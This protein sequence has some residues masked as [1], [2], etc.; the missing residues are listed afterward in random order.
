M[1]WLLAREVL[2]LR[3]QIP[4]EGRWDVVVDLFFY[5][6]PEEVSWFFWFLYPT[7][8]LWCPF[9]HMS[10]HHGDTGYWGCLHHAKHLCDVNIA[11]VAVLSRLLFYKHHV[12]TLFLPFRLR[13]KSR[14]QRKLQLL[15]S[16]PRRTTALWLTLTGP[17]KLQLL[18]QLLRTGMVMLLL[19]LQLPLL[20]LRVL[21]H[22][23][24]PQPLLPLLLKTGQL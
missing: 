2:R 22:L 13:R 10:D 8:N 3:G 17:L 24:M 21:L 11:A 7:F 19:P 18:H 16:R 23:W 4:R 9:K 5:R 15:Q 6:D 1:W 14:L 20:L 12:T